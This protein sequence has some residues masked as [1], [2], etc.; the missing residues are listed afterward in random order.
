MAHEG[1][2]TYGA[3]PSLDPK[4]DPNSDEFVN[5]FLS[6]N[7]I[8]GLPEAGP[9]NRPDGWTEEDEAKSRKEAQKKAAKPDKNF[10]G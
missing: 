5:P 2:R 1:G 9:T 8:L 6:S 3:Q 4:A 10:H 7:A